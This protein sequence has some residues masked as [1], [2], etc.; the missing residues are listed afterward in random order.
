[1]LDSNQRPLPCEGSALPLSQ[2]PAQE[3]TI[4]KDRQEWKHQFLK[5][6]DSHTDLRFYA[7]LMAL[8]ALAATMARTMLQTVQT[9]EVTT[10][11]GSSALWLRRQ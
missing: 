6:G 2:S 9:T 7:D 10:I 4:H 8:A 5:N 1:M 3:R 11:R